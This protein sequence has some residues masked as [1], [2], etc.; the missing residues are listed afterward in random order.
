MADGSAS[1]SEASAPKRR[2]PGRPFEKGK[3]ANPGGYPR[4][5]HGKIMRARRLA[6]KYAPK[7]IETLAE[8]MDDHDPRVRVAAAEGLLDRAGLRPYALE[9][10]RIEVR[11]SVDVEALRAILVARAVAAL[12]AGAGHHQALDLDIPAVDA[13]PAAGR[14]LAERASAPPC[15][16]V[17]SDAPVPT[18]DDLV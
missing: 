8:L 2:G 15:V 11:S 3:A 17:H 16:P 13:L 5:L 14:A 1:A 10:E 6:L 4:E 9:P 18:C 12:G 7:A